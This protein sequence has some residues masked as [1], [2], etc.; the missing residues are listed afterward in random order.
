MESIKISPKDIVSVYDGDTFKIRIS[1]DLK[2]FQEMPVRIIGI[3][4]PEINSKDPYE[5]G[6]AQESKRKLTKILKTAKVITING[7]KRDKYFRL[8]AHVYAGRRSVAKLMIKSG[9]ARHYDG[10][11]RGSWESPIF[12]FKVVLFKAVC[13]SSVLL[14]AYACVAVYMDKV[15]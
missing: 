3:D 2:I 6:L 4:A 10:G 8:Q 5:S 15:G 11:K 12:R 1:S 7:I 13:W 14:M 9:L